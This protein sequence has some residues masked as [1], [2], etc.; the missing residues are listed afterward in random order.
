[1]PTEAEAQKLI[2]KIRQDVRYIRHR[3]DELTWAN[4]LAPFADEGERL[5]NAMENALRDIQLVAENPKQP[6]G[7]DIAATASLGGLHLTAAEPGE[8]Y[9]SMMA[10]WELGSDPPD[11]VAPFVSATQM[12]GY[13]TISGNPTQDF[14]GVVEITSAGGVGAG[15]YRFSSDAGANFTAPATIPSSF[16]HA[17]V[18]VTFADEIDIPDVVPEAAGELPL[19]ASYALG[20]TA[21]WAS[22]G[23]DKLTLSLG[24]S[25]E[26]FDY[27][28]PGATWFTQGPARSRLI[29]A[30][31]WATV[32]RP[33]TGST[34]FSGGQSRV[35]PPLDEALYAEA[36]LEQSYTSGLA[37]KRKWRVELSSH[38]ITR[39]QVAPGGL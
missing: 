5:A 33:P 34:T 31:E 23:F 8:S 11:Q 29:A 14:A 17:G 32:T 25:A 16:E 13:L 19:V 37:W 3:L 20:A 26:S 6:S 35:L 7:A 24:A 28:R 27:L 4:Q 9:N 15:E 22:L 30:A 12:V 38:V 36:E 39:S 1:M 2:T 18:T 10:E 21:S